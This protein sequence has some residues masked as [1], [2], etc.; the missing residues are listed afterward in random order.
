MSDA[1][2]TVCA[3]VCRSPITVQMNDES[4]LEMNK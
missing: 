3:A 1:W 2:V 4:D